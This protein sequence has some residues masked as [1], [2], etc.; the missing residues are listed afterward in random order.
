MSSIAKPNLIDGRTS[1]SGAPEGVDALALAALA[2]DG[3]AVLHIARDDARM[4]R[5]A[6]ALAFFAPSIELLNIP[7]WDCLPYDRVSPSRQTQSLRAASLAH[8]I[9]RKPPKSGRIVLT[10]VSAALQRVPAPEFF[11]GSGFSV[12]VG[13]PVE[14]E[15]LLRYLQDNGFNRT[16]TVREPAEYAVR[17]GIIDIFPPELAD[18]VRLDLFGEEVESI[19]RFDPATQRTVSSTDALELRPV[20]EVLL[21]EQACTRFRSG[22][23]ALFG[24]AGA[25][26]PIYEAVSAGRAFAGMEHWLPLFH[27]R[28]VSLFDY[29]PDC[30]ITFDHQVDEAVVARLETIADYYAARVELA[31]IEDDGGPAYRPIPPERMFL[32]AKEW[33]DCLSGRRLGAFSPYAA[34]DGAGQTIDLGGK[35]GIDLAE[36][37]ARPDVNIFDALRQAIDAIRAAGRRPVLTAYSN[38]SRDRLASV[39]G[40]HGIAP[41]EIAGDWASV[42]GADAGVLPLVVLGLER[43]FTTDALTLIT[44]QDV[45]GERMARP[46]RRRRSAKDVLSELGSLEE[47]DLVVHV[48]HGIG[49]YE[50]LE[51]LSVIAAAPHDCLKIVYA[52]GDR[53]FVPVENMEVLSRY[54]S[55][56][57]TGQL[58]RLGG[59]GW[60]ARKARVKEKIDDIAEGL[61]RIA[62]DRELKSGQVMTPPEGMFDE[63]A[64]RFP[65]LE[66]E[67]QQNAIDDVVADIGSGRP[68]DRLICGDVGF[69]KTEVALRAAFIAVMAGYQ[70][71][72]VV[73]T[74]LLARQHYRTF[75][76]RFSGLPVRIAQLSRLVTPAD[77][78]AAKKELAEGKTE[79]VI[80]TQALLAKDLSFKTLG[81]L[82]VDEEQHFGVKQKER[83]KEL[84][85]DV[86]ILT[87][88]ATPIPRTLQM[89]LTGVREMS[90]MATPPVDR[91]AVRTFV[92]PYDPVVVREAIER[93]LYRGGQIYYVCPRVADMPQLEKRLRKLV[94]DVKIAV[95]HG[96]MAPA[97]LETVMS[98][99][100]DGAYGILLSTN[101]IESG[102]DI[103]SVNTIIIH[104]ADMFGLAQLYQLRG[105]VGR[106]KIR[107]YAY[108]TIPNDRLI[109]ASAE[110][111]LSVMQTLDALGA[112]FSLASYDL[113]IRGAG[114]LL[115]EEQSGHVREVGVELYQKMLEEAVAA[116]RDRTPS[117]EPKQADWSPQI[118][119]GMPVLIPDHYVPDLPARLGL[120]RRISGLVD[121]AEIDAFAAELID[122]FGPLPDE[123]ENL[124]EIVAI[125]RL[126]LA[127]G[128]DKLDA[129][130]KGAILSFH[131]NH[132][133]RPDKLVE[134]LS[135]QAGTVKLRPDHK[136]VYRRQWERTEE[137]I[138]GAKRLMRQLAEIA[139]DSP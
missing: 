100:Y 84:R 99:F 120:Y 20:G 60:Q 33:R 3:D 93:E 134:W 121:R 78:A 112:G 16:G 98:A 67:D 58:D 113:D 57:S 119:I 81:L 123:V 77:A 35:P 73:P 97:D 114:N 49:R 92:L 53:L 15:R 76:E 9:D 31:R 74:T 117:G 65:Y 129:G 13:Q 106:S 18:P 94:P 4:A 34:A 39:L 21:D 36:A 132:F 127:S 126:C 87:L 54:G 41:L 14:P 96:K 55:E 111:R 8:Q 51:T 10:T 40:D 118:S 32:G 95:A 62:A 29:L 66:T 133:A 124:L 88:T 137:R 43:G 135:G 83:L 104:R 47:G 5:L 7:A 19:R 52:G 138:E 128:V 86:H 30:A 24:A 64:A 72:V 105:R 22:Y 50:G 116:A 25:K 48:E 115:G 139:A 2:G 85:A 6:E 38:G 56:D 70:V 79:I 11:A 130:P 102:L 23:R 109:G 71:A 90:L 59:A 80:G 110:K 69:G 27:E 107:A 75:R 89:A 91:L 101:I 1:L 42:T 122:R 61:I 103:P 37:R 82:V 26:D 68:M 44:E 12:A 108:L 17:G 125:K 63:F 46:A 28:L 45:L 136:L 131:N